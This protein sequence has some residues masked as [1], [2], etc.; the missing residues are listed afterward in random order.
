VRANNYFWNKLG[1]RLGKDLRAEP[2]GGEGAGP[3]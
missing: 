3:C 1:G 2:S